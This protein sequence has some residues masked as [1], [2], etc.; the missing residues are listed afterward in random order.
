M[1][2][3][4]IEKCTR[5]RIFEVMRICP[6]DTGGNSWRYKPEKKEKTTRF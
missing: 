2:M 5:L 6:R 1:F 3:K 4:N